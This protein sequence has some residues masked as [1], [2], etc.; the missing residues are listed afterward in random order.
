MSSG[1]TFYN[2][3]NINMSPDMNHPLNHKCYGEDLCPT[4]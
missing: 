4:E 3:I 1:S 2:K